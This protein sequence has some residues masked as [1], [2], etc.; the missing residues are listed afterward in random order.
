MRMFLTLQTRAAPLGSKEHVNV[1]A[2]R[3]LEDDDRTIYAGRPIDL[4]K[5]EVIGQIMKITTFQ[6][7]IILV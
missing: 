5:V 3:P 4:K 1:V 6:Q 7:P 2:C